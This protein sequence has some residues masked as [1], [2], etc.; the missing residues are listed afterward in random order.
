M[1]C[2]YFRGLKGEARST[3][4]FVTETLLKASTHL[5]AFFGLILLGFLGDRMGRKRMYTTGLWI[6]FAAT[7]ASAFSANLVSGMNVFSEFGMWRVFL[8]VGLGLSYTMIAMIASEVCQRSTIHS[9]FGFIFLYV[10]LFQKVF[11]QQK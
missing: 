5:G 8:G 3:V 4:P 9:I 2:T 11:T 10:F 1:G 6:S 7:L